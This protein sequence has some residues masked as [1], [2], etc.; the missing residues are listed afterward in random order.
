MTVD[1]SRVAAVHETDDLR[2]SN[3]VLCSNHIALVGRLPIAIHQFAET[4]Y[5]ES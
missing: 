4:L 3:G 2:R 1:A 5:E